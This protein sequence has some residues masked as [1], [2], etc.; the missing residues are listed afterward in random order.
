MIKFVHPAERS[1]LT[2]S[3]A[4][5]AKFVRNRATHSVALEGGRSVGNV[6]DRTAAG[7][8]RESWRLLP[9]QLTAALRPVH[10]GHTDHSHVLGAERWRCGD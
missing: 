7:S 4:P 3:L 5:C 1:V 2:L 9:P 8:P 10:D 6:A